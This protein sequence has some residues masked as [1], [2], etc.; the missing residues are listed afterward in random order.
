MSAACSDDGNNNVAEALISPSSVIRRLSPN[1]AAETMKEAVARRAPILLQAMLPGPS[2]SA[3]GSRDVLLDGNKGL[4]TIEVLGVL[5]GEDGSLLL[6]DCRPPAPA[7]GRRPEAGR[8]SQVLAAAAVAGTSAPGLEIE[9]AITV[10]GTAFAFRTRLVGSPAA[11]GDCVLR[12]VKPRSIYLR[13]RRRSPRRKLRE[14]ARV[15]LHL[16]DEEPARPCCEA[17]MLNLSS[18]GMACR[19]ASREATVLSEGQTIRVRFQL[20]QGGAPFTLRARISNLTLGAGGDRTVVGLEFVAD[21]AW[22][23]GRGRFQALLGSSPTAGG[24]RGL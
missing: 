3:G 18:E 15:E 13:E 5:C 9:G 14:G 8:A 2:R 6:I 24:K 20:P 17:V 4:S 10:G 22:K 21:A 23:A 19:M 12:I 16:V 7:S 1:L 11:M